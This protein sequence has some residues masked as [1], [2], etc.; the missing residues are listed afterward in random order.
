MVTFKKLLVVSAIT[1]ATSTA[2]L[3]SGAPYLGIGL[4]LNDLLATSKISDTDT[5][6]TQHFGDRGAELNVFGGYGQTINQNLYLGAEL[7]GSKASTEITS[8]ELKESDLDLKTTFTPKYSYG[9]SL[10]P[11]LMIS[12]HTMAFARLGLV[13]TKFDA[14]ITGKD[15]TD[16]GSQSTQKTLT[17]A[18]FGLGLQTSLTSNVDLRGEYVYTAY[19]SM[20]VGGDNGMKIT[21]NSGTASVGLIYKF[22]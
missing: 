22:E 11:G 14:K 16:E 13:Q 15:S 17:G 9:A 19:R 5:T 6:F 8:N 7:F 21:P 4:G 12:D 2:A 18:Q 20:N 10:I 1:A 3:A